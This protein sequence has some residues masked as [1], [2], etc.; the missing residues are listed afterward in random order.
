MF[1]L[2]TPLKK[3][4]K[5]MWYCPSCR[6]IEQNQA[7]INFLQKRKQEKQAAK[8]TPIVTNENVK[9]EEP[10]KKTKKEK[11]ISYRD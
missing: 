10:P 8:S 2:A 9:D 4:P 3:I 7:L 5:G 6:L 1:C 11:K